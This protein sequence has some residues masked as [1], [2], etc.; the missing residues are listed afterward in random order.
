[1]EQQRTALV[2]NAEVIKM[3]GMKSVSGLNKLRVRDKTFP[4]RSRAVTHGAHGAA[5]ILL[6]LNNGLP[7][8]MPRA[9][10]RLPQISKEKGAARNRCLTE[11]RFT[12]PPNLP[13]GSCLESSCYERPFE[14]P[15]TPPKESARAENADIHVN[16]SPKAME[17]F[18]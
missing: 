14:K 13:T 2:G 18:P 1:M 12:P 11:R 7:T 17:Q 6:R 8:R 4:G 15:S 5:S 3:L 9:T 10:S 16:Y